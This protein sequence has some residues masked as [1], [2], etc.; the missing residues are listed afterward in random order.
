VTAQDNYNY[1]ND[2]S[3]LPFDVPQVLN[4]LN[5]YTLPFGKGKRFFNTDNAVANLLIRDWTLSS[6]HQYRSGG[7]ILV[8]APANT[9]GTGV[10]FTGFKA[11]N[12][13]SGPIRT[14]VD[15]S[16]LDPNNPASVWLNAGA[17][18]TPGQFQ[19]GNAAHYYNDFRN[20]PVLVDNISVQKRMRFPVGGDRTVD[21]LYRADAF[22]AFNRTSFGGIN[23]I[24]GNPNFG[25]PAGP[26][27]GARVITMGLRLEF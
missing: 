25:R 4:I 18:S 12:V 16:S 15:R 26:Q 6:I 22:N 1:Q 24:I 14:N 27:V 19:L 13:G 7:L 2:K 9:L 10:L 21:L 11:A 23:G 3:F 17:F 8:Q 20:P 5:S